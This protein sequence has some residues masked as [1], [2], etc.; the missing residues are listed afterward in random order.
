MPAISVVIAAY[1]AEAY[2]PETIRSVLAQTFTDWELT[3]VDDGSKDETGRIAAG[4]AAEDQRIRALAQK[5]QGAAVARNHGFSQ[6]HADARYVIFLDADDV[7]ERTTLET[8]HSTLEAHP[9]AVAVHGLAR[10][11][12]RQTQPLWP[13]LCE[14]KCR[15]R[16]TLVGNRV[17]SLPLTEP[18]T[19]GTLIVGGCITT[20]SILI[21]R[22]VLEEMGVF[23]TGFKQCEDWDLYIRLSRRG[24]ILFCDKVFLNYR[25]HDTNVT[26]NRAQEREMER[27]VLR[28]AFTSPENTEEQ[29]RM[30]LRSFRAGQLFFMASKIR[31]AREGV[32]RKELRTVTSQFRPLC[33]HVLK[34]VQGKP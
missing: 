18:T 28:K 9:E 23:D 32:Q 22:A 29:R 34:Y 25:M 7:W 5:N 12:D 21:R 33:G 30:V 6:S 11:V 1:N 3:V 19:F 13:G 17:V 16:A 26:K 24:P 20:G 15:I 2:L 27:Q 14:G 4:F 10:Y 8:L 31:Y